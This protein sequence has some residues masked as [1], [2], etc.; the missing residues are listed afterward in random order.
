VLERDRGANVAVGLG[1]GIPGFWPGKGLRNE[2][3]RA[4]GFLGVMRPEVQKGCRAEGGD[5]GDALV[6]ATFLVR[7]R[8]Y[9]FYP[10]MRWGVMGEVGGEVR[11]EGKGLAWRVGGKGR[12][13]RSGQRKGRLVLE[14]RKMGKS[15]SRTWYF[16]QNSGWHGRV[17]G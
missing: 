8:G 6:Q 17:C 5:D 12:K 2:P 13:G 1:I 9:F 15:R 10:A 7:S 16:G 14:A 11:W 3:T 4:L